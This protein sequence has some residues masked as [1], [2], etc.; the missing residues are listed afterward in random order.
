[1]NK[2]STV[3]V[4]GAGN[5]GRE[6]YGS[7]I[8]EHPGDIKAVA[9]AEPDADKRALFSKEH[10]IDQKLQFESWEK[11]LNKDRVAD[12]IIIA[13]LDNM[14][15]EP[16]L[17][18]MEKGYKILLEKPIAPDLEDLIEIYKKY[19]ETESEIL[20]AHVLRYTNFF[21]K[22]KEL[23]DEKVIG[24]VRYI[25]LN[26]NI[27]YYHF[28]HSYVRGNW[29]NTDSAA[30]II[31]AKSC[32]DLDILH[33][34]LGT[35]TKKLTSFASLE[36]FKEESQPE[37]AADRCI[38]CEIE[39]DCPYSA[40]KIYLGEN[41]DWPTSVI[42][43]NLSYEGRFKAL[44]EGPYGRCV[45]KSDNNVPDVQRVNMTQSDNTEVNFT[46]NAFSKDI[47]RDIKIHGSLGEIEGDF[48]KGII[49]LSIFGKSN[50]VI[51]IEAASGHHGGGDSGLMSQ[52]VSLLKGKAIDS[53]SSSLEESL[54]SH[55]M[56][57]AAEEARAKN[58]VINLTK[59]RQEQFNSI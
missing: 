33:W 40:R 20:V 5:R 42:T 23:L 36:I 15:L 43:T 39:S 13:T 35:K 25:D 9:V 30:P 47:T 27:G 53:W 3:A 51:E 4:L 2:I 56:A 37:N 14:H 17:Q 58:S 57:F 46:L 45:W 32:H 21:S 12:G 34:L 26:E 44:K 50:S 54:E 55:L 11:L 29:R 8:L 28:A 1:M 16:V 22:L 48:E 38:Y 31:L 41:T 10:N 49:E 52:F 24:K 7:Y 59:W 19:K 18:A 6:A